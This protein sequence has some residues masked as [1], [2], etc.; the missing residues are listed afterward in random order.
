MAGFGGVAY[1]KWY[2]LTFLN[3]MCKMVPRHKLGAISGLGK[4]KMMGDAVKSGVVDLV[5]LLRPF[6]KQ[7]HLIIT[8]MNAVRRPWNPEC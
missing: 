7:L 6:T 2:N 8:G 3:T 5:P 1:I 4:V